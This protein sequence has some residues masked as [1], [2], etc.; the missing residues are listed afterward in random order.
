MGNGLLYQPN[1]AGGIGAVP[2]G[3][4][5]GEQRWRSGDSRRAA[6]FFDTVRTARLAVAQVMTQAIVCSKLKA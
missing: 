2:A 3:C 4:G 6:E 1:T 5:V